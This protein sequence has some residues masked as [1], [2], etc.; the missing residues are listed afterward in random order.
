MKKNDDFVEGE[1]AVVKIDSLAGFVL[2]FLPPLPDLD[3]QPH[4][5][6]KITFS[7][8]FSLQIINKKITL[9]FIRFTSQIWTA[10]FWEYIFC[11]V[12]TIKDDCIEIFIDPFEKKTVKVNRN[13]LRQL[14]W[15]V[16]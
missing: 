16:F 1:I 15:F 8:P 5:T 9:F 4:T 14:R 7:P 10:E 11:R 12:S 6:I 2:F 3:L 13:D